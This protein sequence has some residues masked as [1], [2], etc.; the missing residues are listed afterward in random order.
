MKNV[1]YVNSNI[2]LFLFHTNLFCVS[3][4]CSPLIGT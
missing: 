1:I 4:M 3:V 2:L